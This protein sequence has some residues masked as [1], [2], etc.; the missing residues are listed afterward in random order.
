LI[1]LGFRE[2]GVQRVLVTTY[3]DNPASRRVM[4][5]AGLRY[6]R[7]FRL[8]PDDLSAGG[9]FHSTSDELWDGDDVEYALTKEEWE[10]RR[11]A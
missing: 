2:H 1:D 7:A 9:S 8:T 10:L 3:Q 4:E 5:R 11:G 6:A